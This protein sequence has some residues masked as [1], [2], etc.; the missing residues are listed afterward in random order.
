MKS[1]Y[2]IGNGFDIHH[3]IKS[4][5]S[6]YREW[7]KEY[8]FDLYDKLCRLYDSIDEDDGW[9][10]SFEQHLS[11]IS[12]DYINKMYQ[13]YS[14]IYGSEDF[15]DAD[16]HRA[17][18]Q[19]GLD[20]DIDNLIE[21]IGQSLKVWIS[22]LN[23]PNCGKLRIADKDECYFLT[24]NYT[25]TLEDVYNIPSEQLCHIHGSI[26]DSEF[27][28]GHG[29]NTSE[30]HDF[31]KGK[32][33]Q[34]PSGLTVEQTKKWLDANVDDSTMESI[35]E[36]SAHQLSRMKKN[37]P[38]II[39]QKHKLFESLKDVRKIYILGFSFSP[40]DIPYLEEVLYNIIDVDKVLWIATAHTS[41]DEKAINEFIDEHNLDAQK[42]CITKMDAL[43]I[44]KEQVLEFKQ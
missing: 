40:I 42:W 27:V 4:R 9:W 26:D 20:I 6:D 36:T 24:F 33:K 5:Y 11:A 35:I 22:S 28:W 18:I 16:Y 13:D 7:L 31:L 32:P 8:D 41:S 43:D 25:K 10:N 1:L 12:F 39:K 19:V 3:G 38:G 15:R 29:K 14:P 17:S 21:N 44:Y 34:Q 2:I 30:I 37:V 23:K